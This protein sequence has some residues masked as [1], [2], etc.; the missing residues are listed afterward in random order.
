MNDYDVVIVGGKAAAAIAVNNDLVDEDTTLAVA[1]L[2]T[3]H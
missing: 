1:A 3:S 2:R